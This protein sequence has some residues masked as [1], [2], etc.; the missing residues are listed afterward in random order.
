MEEHNRR[1][2]T[3]CGKNYEN[4]KEMVME[5]RIVIWQNA[6]V[7]NDNY[8]MFLRFFSCPVKE[9]FADTQL[10]CFA[11]WFSCNSSKTLKVGLSVVLMDYIIFASLAV[12]GYAN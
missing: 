2:E 4:E 10:L 8:V 7:L 12:R 5:M 6:I 11:N 9:C 3:E 1:A